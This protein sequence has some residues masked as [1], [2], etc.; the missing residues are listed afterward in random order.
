MNDNKRILDK[1][2]D[3]YDKYTEKKT[4][5]VRIY[6]VPTKI[7]SFF[8]FLFSG[9][10]F[11]LLLTMFNFNLVYF[12]LLLGS[13]SIAIYYGINLFTDKGIGLPR[14]VEVPVTEEEETKIEDIN[15]DKKSNRYKVQ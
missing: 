11:I 4:K 10:F 1:F 13:L 6:V 15:F 2:L 12:M 5:L 3:S 8:G 9:I 7:R 14:T